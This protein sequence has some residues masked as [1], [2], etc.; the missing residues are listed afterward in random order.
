MSLRYEPSRRLAAD[1][2]AGETT[3]SPE[4]LEIGSVERAKVLRAIDAGIEN[5]DIERPQCENAVEKVDDVGLLCR[6]GSDRR[7]AATGGFDLGDDRF[8]PRFGAS[9]R[10]D[11]QTFKGKTVAERCSKPALRADSD[12]QRSAFGL[13]QNPPPQVVVIAETIAS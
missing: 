9:D 3:D 1:E 10:D 6:I 5:D 4:C 13:C 12:D 7:G 8:E 2:K 11:M